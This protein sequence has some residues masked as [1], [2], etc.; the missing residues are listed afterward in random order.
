MPTRSH[1][2]SLQLS[3]E[4][5]ER[6]VIATEGVIQPVAHAIRERLVALSQTVGNAREMQEHRDDFLTFRT[7]ESN[8]VSLAQNSWRK[9]LAQVSSSSTG[10]LAPIR[11]PRLEL[12]G[13]EVVETGILSSR[14][15]QSI[16]DKANFELSD[17]RLRIQH[18]EGTTELDAKD[19]L[20]PGVA[21]QGAGRSMAGRGLES[22]ALGQGPGSGANAHDRRRRQSLQGRQR[23]PRREG[24]DAR[25]RPQELRQAHR[26]R[27]A[28][29]T[30]QLRER[31][32]RLRGVPA[33]RQRARWCGRR[34]QAS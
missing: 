7:K 6:F 18:L 21:G 20:K 4:T 25:D 26:A 32:R 11:C 24:C 8:W 27:S 19:V 22:R 23:L 31:G 29:A 30:R 9:A 34:Q 16:Q 12:I 10:R 1:A 17:L 14:L 15:A 13:D 28:P 3:R 33:A 2:S 5:R